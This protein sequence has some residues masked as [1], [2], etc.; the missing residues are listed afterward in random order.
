L[1]IINDFFQQGKGVYIWGDRAE[2]L[3]ANA[4]VSKLL[5]CSMSPHNPYD[6]T[7]CSKA[8]PNREN[9]FIKHQITT[10][11]EFLYEGHTIAQ[12]HYSK[13]QLVPILRGGSDGHVGTACY[14]SNGKRAIIDGGFTRLYMRWDDAGTGLR[15]ENV[16]VHKAEDS[17]AGLARF[18]RFVK[19]AAAWLVNWE[20]FNKVPDKAI[21]LQTQRLS[22]QQA[23]IKPKSPQ[24]EKKTLRSQGSYRL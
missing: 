21:N 15:I 17:L 8:V 18:A 2:S 4:V 23:L 1:N 22:N 16:P 14:D 20:R 12:I 19:N 10:G 5:G 24:E 13:E 11:L 3:D 6:C 7:V 9:R